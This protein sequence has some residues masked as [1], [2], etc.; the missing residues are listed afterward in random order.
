MRNPLGF[1]PLL[2]DATSGKR[3]LAVW[4][5]TDKLASLIVAIPRHKTKK[6]SKITYERFER[7]LTNASRSIR[8]KRKAAG[9]YVSAEAVRHAVFK[10]LKNVR[11]INCCLANQTRTDR[12][13]RM[14]E[15][16][17]KPCKKI[18]LSNNYVAIHSAI[19]NEVESVRL[20]E[21]TA[22]GVVSQEPSNSNIKWRFITNKSDLRLAVTTAF[23]TDPV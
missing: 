13:I 21:S 16:A 4:S 9:H 19:L 17:Y 14:L 6:S 11:L 10:S 5:W 20:G 18:T 2:D 3:S 8:Q 7:T 15:I 23:C 22:K 1:V 12:Y